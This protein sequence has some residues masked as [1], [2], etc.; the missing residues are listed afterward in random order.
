MIKNIYFDLD[1]TLYDF[2]TA[3][4]LAVNTVAGYASEKYGASK[5]YWVDKYNEYMYRQEKEA[6]YPNSGMHSRTIR[7]KLILEELGQKVIPGAGEL[8]HLYWKTLIDSISPGH[9]IDTLLKSLHENGYHIGLATNM[10]SY[11]QFEKIR[12]LGLSDYFDSLVTSEEAVFE[13]PQRQFFEYI[14][15]FDAADASTSL[16]IGDNLRLDVLASMECGMRALFY[17]GN[18][19]SDKLNAA[20]KLAENK[21]YRLTEFRGS[22]FDLDQITGWNPD[23]GEK[24]ADSVKEIPYIQ[25]FDQISI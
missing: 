14:L 15:G 22:M 9:G 1:N 5:E 2:D 12:V 6:P 16:M 10:T 25:D 7:Y 19:S 3:S 17:T 23:P 21:G 24:S 20:A 18:L 4:D 11:V 13:K 8:G